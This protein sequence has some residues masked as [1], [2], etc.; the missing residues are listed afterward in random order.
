YDHTPGV[1]ARPARYVVP[2]G[3]VVVPT[4]RYIVPAGKV[5]IIVSTGRLSLV[6]TGRVLS[7]GSDNDSDDAS[8]HS[9]ATIPQQQRN[10]Q[11]QYIT[12]ISN[13]NGAKFFLFKNDDYED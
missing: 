13:N 11:P 3:R 5:I 1:L 7:P 12:T 8:V 10:N 4:G 2:T 9:E 6:P